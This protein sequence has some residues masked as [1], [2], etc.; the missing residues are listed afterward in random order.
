MK[1]RLTG[2]FIFK[3]RC[4]VAQNENTE[5][6]QASKI[7]NDSSLGEYDKIRE[8]YKLGFSRKQLQG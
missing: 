3:R 7:L 8:L 6:N 4:P 2:L 5:E 1:A